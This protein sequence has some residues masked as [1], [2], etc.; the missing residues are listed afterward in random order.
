MHLLPP[1]TVAWM[2]NIVWYVYVIMLLYVHI[3]LTFYQMTNFR[4][5]QSERVCRQQFQVWRKWKKVIQ[6]D[7]K[8]CGKRRN[9]SLQQFLLFPQCFQKGCFSGVSKGVIVWEWINLLPHN[10]DFWCQRKK[11]F[12]NMGNEKMLVTNI[13]SLTHGVFN[14]TIKHKFCLK[15]HI[16]CGREILT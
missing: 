14:Y 12:E 2:E 16:I 8:H 11:H 1:K 9:C 6:T 7:R 5:F 3:K 4:L 13:F 10:Y 15:Q